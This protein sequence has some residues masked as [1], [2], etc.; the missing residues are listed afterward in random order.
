MHFVLI[1]IDEVNK[2]LARDKQSNA[3]NK[4]GTKFC[5]LIIIKGLLKNILN[6][7]DNLVNYNRQNSSYH[8]T[9]SAKKRHSLASL[10]III[11]IESNPF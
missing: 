4:E 10:L 6:I 9:L 2:L 3:Y 11:R 7:F 8:H 5:L 1:F